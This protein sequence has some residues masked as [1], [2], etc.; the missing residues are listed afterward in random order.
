MPGN[1]EVT[2]VEFVAGNTAEMEDIYRH[3]PFA[4]FHQH[5]LLIT[6]SV[7]NLIPVQVYDGQQAL[8]G[9]FGLEHKGVHTYNLQF[10]PIVRHHDDLVTLIPHLTHWL[11][12]KKQAW[13]L[14]VQLPLPLNAESKS[15]MC[16]LKKRIPFRR[17]SS[18]FNWCSAAIDLTRDSDTLWKSFSA[19]HRRNIRRARDQDVEYRFVRDEQSVRRLSEIFVDMYRNRRLPVNPSK[20]RGLFSAIHQILEK[21][22]CGFILGSYLRNELI[23]GIIIVYQGSS[24]FYYAGA[25]DPSIRDVPVH[26]GAFCRAIQLAKD[27]GMK[28]FDFGGIDVRAEK[29]SQTS[30]INAFKL[31]F[32]AERVEYVPL[33]VFD[34]RPLLSRLIELAIN[35][36][37]RLT[38]LSRYSLR[39]LMS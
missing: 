35:G 10:G 21:T 14:T 31:G 27:Q 33:C 13:R 29:G 15:L 9:Y 6:N 1:H 20:T 24:A 39:P 37:N 36:R 19:H 12:S 28:H 25:S 8:I 34:L 5:P 17:S 18:L 22:A 4:F 23:G 26:H 32:G 38:A 7:S 16:D 3:F 30:R 2:F 11:K